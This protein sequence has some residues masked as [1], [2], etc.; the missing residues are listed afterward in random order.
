MTGCNLW[1]ACPSWCYPVCWLEVTSLLWDTEL[2]ALRDILNSSFHKA[3]RRNPGTQWIT[4]PVHKHREMHG[5]ASVD[6]KS[7][8][9]G[10]A[11]RVPPHSWWLPYSLEK[12][13]YFPAPPLQGSSYAAL[14][15]VI[16]LRKE[17]CGS[18][19]Q[20]LA[21]YNMKLVQHVTMMGSPIPDT[22]TSAETRASD[23]SVNRVPRMRAM[24]H[25]LYPGVHYW[26]WNSERTGKLEAKDTW[27]GLHVG[28]RGQR[29]SKDGWDLS[30]RCCTLLVHIRKQL[31]LRLEHGTYP[32][33]LHRGCWAVLPSCKISGE[34]GFLVE[35]LPPQAPWTA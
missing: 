20:Y 23:S 17:V 27:A 19:L 5:P 7:H 28:D 11:L 25:F 12:V 26:V 1:Q 4:K 2:D 22:L 21:M 31:V 16:L 10:K 32:V 9:L 15:G 30:A 18:L 29:D 33:L 13:Q 14:D 35:L 3:I 8:G 34:A 6:G 24:P